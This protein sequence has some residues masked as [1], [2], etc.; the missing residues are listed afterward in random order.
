MKAVRLRTEYL[1]N[2]I[3][4]DFQYPRLMWNCE[5]GV[6]QTAYQIVTNCWNSGRVESDSMR[7]EYPKELRERERV[8][9][10]IRLWDENNEPGDWSEAFFEMGIRSWQAQWITGD[11]RVDPQKRTPVDCFRKCFS[12]EKPVKRARLYIT[13]C[14]LYEAR[15]GGV[16]VGDFFMAPGH[17][18]YNKRVQ[19]QTYD[20]T[21]MLQSGENEL[22]VQLADGWYRGSCGAHGLKNQYGTE[23]KLLAQL[24]ITLEDGGVQTVVSDESWD[25]SND[26]PIRFADN[27]DGELVEAF[28]VPLFRG[29][30]KRTKHNVIPTASNNVPVTEHERFTP[31]LITTPS[32]RTVLDFGQNIAGFVAFTLP[33]RG[34]ERVFL[35]F[36]EMLDRN[37]EF[38]QKNIQLD[39]R[40]YTTPLQQV[41]YFCKEGLNEYRTCFAVFGFRYAL[42]ET[43]LPFKPEDFTAVAVYS[44]MEQT[45]F[46]RSSHELL[47]RFVDATVWSAKGNHLDIPTDCPTRERHGWT[48]DAQIF[49]ESAGILFDFAAFSK[50]YLND[51]YDWQ[52]KDGKLPH[53]APQG[54]ADASMRPMNGSVGWSDVGI[55]IP[56]RFWRLFGDETILREYYDG[57]AKYARFMEK[58]CGKSM[59]LIAERI[60]LSKE[61]ARWLVNLGQSY[62]EWAEPEDVCPFRWQ[63]FVAPHPEV[64]T[65]YTAWVLSLMAEIAAQLGKT[66]DEK[67]FREYAEGCR[68]AYQELVSGGKYT[69]DTDRQAQ[70]VRPLALG[71]LTDEQKVFAQKRLIEALEHYGWRLGTGFLSTPLILGVLAEYDL[72]AAYRLLENEEIPGWL[73]MPKNG[74]STVWENWEGDHSEHP[75]SLNHYSKGA[76]CEWLFETMCG[77]RVAGENRFVLAPRPGGS[78]TF[79][80]ASYKSACGRVASRWEKLDGKTVYTF[81]VPA[82]CEAEIRLPGGIEKTVGTGEYQFE[83]V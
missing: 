42:V 18:D 68:K 50:K 78:F 36:G 69:L 27:K 39:Y 5:G 53:I 14:G 41:E 62:G 30:A 65:A 1:F 28:R 66:D 79:A 23:T 54:G 10:K 67:E 49:F 57:M 16:K 47:N 77:I 25:W 52:Q 31:T 76:V 64:S 58:R 29:K 60:K 2:P 24:E 51:V 26:G 56:Y 43:D 11:Y 21:A 63:D 48:G 61:N 38:T 70:L 40:G 34:G 72:D 59:P 45:G 55:L 7:A 12:V 13:A 3:G 71:L 9:W 22:T 19:V 4:V 33:A 20:V 75:A 81:T 74:A 80:E 15:L 35:R 17:T 44:D 73:S 6:K 46:F 32:G 37:R 83:E 8:S 82:N